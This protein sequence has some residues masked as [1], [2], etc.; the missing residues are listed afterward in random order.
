ME[1]TDISAWVG[2]H[3]PEVLLLIGGLLAIAIVVCYVKDK[4]SGK[5]KVM[6]AL[7]VIFG[8]L[9]AL[10]AVA[11][12]GEWRMVTS[13]LVSIAAFALIIRP[14]RDVHF[15]IIIAVLAMALVYIGL[16]GLEGYML[17]DSVDMSFMAEGI[18]RIVAA[19]LIGAV[20]YM[21]LNFAESLVKLVG[22]I[23]N[24]WPLLLV[25]GI[26]CIAEAA[27]MLM[28]YGSIS[29]YIDTSSLTS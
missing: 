25:L 5:Y 26:I 22:K 27:C 28:G 8:V 14:F 7:G 10:E 1:T 17:F 12:Y 24:W 21:I 18:P 11:F 3:L 20:V 9:M 19:F 15:A 16:G 23:L 4:E 6:M 29:D 13:V 2:D